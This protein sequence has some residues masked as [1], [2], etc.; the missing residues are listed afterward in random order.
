MTFKKE[1]SRQSLSE[2]RVT[3]LKLIMLLNEALVL[4]NYPYKITGY[5]KLMGTI[6]SGP[7]RDCLVFLFMESHRAKNI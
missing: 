1:K 6:L 2:M 5:R 4:N 7:E 3:L